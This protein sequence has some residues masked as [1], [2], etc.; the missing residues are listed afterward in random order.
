M[1]SLTLTNGTGLASNYQIAASGNS[2]TVTAATLTLNGSKIYDS[3][4]TFAASA[5]GAGGTVGTG[6]NGQSLVLTG[7][8]SVG[9]ANVSAGT[10]ALTL[11]SLTLTNGTGLASN[12]Q[13][14]S[15]GNAGAITPATL[16]YVANANS[17]AFGSAVPSQ[18]HGDRLRRR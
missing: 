18:R 17:M 10:Q 14:G 4:T 6:I 16:T 9:S 11:G 3:T 1:G 5:F 8:G 12:Y 13:L 2:G 15:S 7:F